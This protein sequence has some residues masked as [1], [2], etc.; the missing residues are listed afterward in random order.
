MNRI[1]TFTINPALS[2]STSYIHLFSDLAQAKLHFDTLILFWLGE[3]LLHPH[4]F[5]RSTNKPFVLLHGTTFLSRIEV[6]TNAVHGFQHHRRSA[7][8]T[9]HPFLN[10]S[11]CLWMRR[12]Q[13][14][15][16]KSK[17]KINF[18]RLHDTAL[19]FSAPRSERCQMAQTRVSI[20]LGRKQH[21]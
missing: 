15:T 10:P 5:N 11:I 4:I 18:D 9:L 2:I 14:R 6:H 12:L 7:P 19:S 17:E 13:R 16:T 1:I 3:P 8:L 20:Y 21:P